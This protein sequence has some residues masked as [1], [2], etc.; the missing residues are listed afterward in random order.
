M[1][2]T[3][4]NGKLLDSVAM[5]V[6]AAP[7]LRLLLVGAISPQAASPA[8]E[9]TDYAQF[10]A[11][12]YR[13][14]V[15]TSGEYSRT[16][17]IRLHLRNATAVT[18]FGQL[19]APY[20]D[21]YGDVAFE[22]VVLE[23]PDGRKVEVK[24]GLVEDINPFGITNTGVSSDVR[25]K[26]LTIPGIE[27]GDRLSY[28]IVIRQKP[29][30]PGRVFGQMKLPL[31]LGEPAQIYEL[32]LP[33]SANI[34][35][36]LRDGLGATWE[37]LPGP[38]D[39]LVRRLSVK[40]KRPD[41]K[42]KK[43]TKRM[44]QEWADP[45]V[46][47][48]SFDDWNQVAQ[49]WW[50]LARDRVKPDAA[51][52]AETQALATPALSA[53]QKLVAIHE[54]VAS[55]IRYLNVG[56]GI[57]RMQPRLATQV[58]ASRYGDCKDA[59]ALLAALASAA[60]IDVRPAL[61]GRSGPD[62]HDDVPAP[63]Q[64]DHVI[65]VARL[66]SDPASWLWLDPTNPY[67]AAGYLSSDLRNKRALIIEPSG[68][69]R[70]VRTPEEPPF[71]PRMDIELK[72][73]L[74]PDGAL[75]GRNVWTMRS[76]GEVQW[77]AMLA[78]VPQNRRAEA[79][80]AGLATA[81]KNPTVTNAVVSDV[82]ATADA[83]RVEFDAEQ[84]APA[85]AQGDWSLKVPLPDFGLVEADDTPGADPLEFDER[86]YS[87]RA[88]I[89]LPQ[90]LQA[91][92][93]LSV[94]LERPF[95]RFE[96]VYAI[97][98]RTLK[99]S[100]LLTLAKRV[101]APE[102]IPAYEALRKAIDTD[103]D[104][105]FLIIGV[106]AAM[107]S[108]SAESLHNEG[109][110]ALDRKEYAKAVEL[111]QKA[112]AADAKTK[113]GFFDLGR[114]LVSAGKNAE[115]LQAFS[116]QVE[117]SPFHESAYAWRASVYDKL[118]LAEDAEKDL[119]KQIEVAP[120]SVWSYETLASRRLW[121]KRFHES[122]DLYARAAAIQPKE[123]GRWVDLGWAYARDGRPEEARSA[124]AQAR[125]LNLPDWMKI[126]AGGAYALI[127]ESAT[128]AELASDGLA[129][130]AQRLTALSADAVN[131]N[132][133]WGAEY[134]ARAWYLI[135]YAALASG[136]QVTAERYLDAAWRV[137]FLP[138][139]AWAL[140][141]LRE[142]QSRLAEAVTFWSMAAYVPTAALNLP[143]DRQSRIEA[144]CR[145]LPLAQPQ[146]PEVEQPVGAT[147]GGLVHRSESVT[148]RPGPS[149]QIEAQ[150]RLMELRTVALNGPVLADFTEEVLLLASPDGTVERLQNLSRRNPVD[151]ERQLA[152]LGPIRLSLT[153]PDERSFKAV[154][155]GLL[156]CS[157]AT[158]CVVILDL[159]GLPTSRSAEEHPVTAGQPLA[160]EQ[161]DPHKI[162]REAEADTRAGHYELALKKYLW[163]HHNALQIEPSLRGV[164]LSF[165]LSAWF[166]LGA[167]YP[168]ALAALRNARDQALESVK[169]EHARD[170]FADFVAINRTLSEEAR[171]VEA[172]VALDKVD[173]ATARQVFA[174]ARPALLRAKDYAL[175]GKYLNPKE[176]FSL[177][178]DLYRM[179]KDAPDDD[180]G[181]R[182]FAE[183][184]FSN[185]TTTLIALLVVN[186]R[187][188]EAKDIASSAK[189]AWAATAFHAAVEK[190]LR[191]EVP[192]PW[193]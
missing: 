187:Q 58:L 118:S 88:E 174:K 113:D 152:K 47:F 50:S 53:R 19:G 105:K 102:E 38:A 65:G 30:A 99:V 14:R 159:P 133:L 51:I 27:A 18:E 43:L 10:E 153:S 176:D 12:S 107:D 155:R 60:G 41:P 70:I 127:G 87:A 34:R 164:R 76:D 94:T 86:E 33:R 120:F 61:L 106:R 108:T 178:V 173:P 21:G 73:D 92:A 2:L 151:F 54:F 124:L 117:I 129:S 186:G 15:E 170:P 96:S 78:A 74:Q 29:L 130:V 161:P 66:G 45:D 111:L 156:A 125:S 3:G 82:S 22:D 40:V 154:R 110:A 100:R 72:A 184:K 128:A 140:G 16:W 36:R 101:L 136:N 121:Q 119:L 132:D 32:D 4:A 75:R 137:W 126:S 39:R 131:E 68:E 62:L 143:P 144:A 71:I 8:A 163:F 31:L 79:L 64:F 145:R 1:Y 81:W 13:D 28:R 190:A 112:T 149:Q 141:N 69:G 148:V 175:C 165:A 59:Y 9:A 52:Q 25:F 123:A 179:Q 77:R 90:G 5:S 158:S 169:R 189:S 97:E 20:I 115:A 188:E 142:K 23:K 183:N 185:D 167:V 166:R 89:K 98:G 104:Q 37:E 193:P 171:T 181:L 7:L 139:A 83:L 93:P 177:S 35:V 182:T 6:F 46:L 85:A 17:Q 122:A 26:K 191:G 84:P 49:W 172:F 168:P 67:G 138:D 192:E 160:L 11:V 162:L 150:Q 103:R 42:L 157:R 114:A 146:A 57:G 48:S 134:L 116:R 56:F 24:N 63:Q 80:K 135:G 44:V 91:R 55:K 180:P 109:V 95:G 147:K